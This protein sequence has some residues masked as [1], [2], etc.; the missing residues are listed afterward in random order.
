MSNYRSK[1]YSF[2]FLFPLGNRL[3]YRP[4]LNSTFSLNQQELCPESEN[5]LPRLDSAEA[6]WA[7]HLCLRALEL[8]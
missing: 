8:S 5:G 1:S 3:I 2:S 4:F 7:Y 6:F